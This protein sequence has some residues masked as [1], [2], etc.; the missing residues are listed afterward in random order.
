MV[1]VVSSVGHSV[2]DK[3]EGLAGEVAGSRVGGRQEGPAAQLRGDDGHDGAL[4]HGK[5]VF[6]EPVSDNS[7][8]E[9]NV[10][11]E[12]GWCEEGP[13]RWCVCDHD[14]SQAEMNATLSPA[15]PSLGPHMC[16][17]KDHEQE[18]LGGPGCVR[19]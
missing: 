17:S 2:S 13:S 3:R 10:V 16:Q 4:C 5:V 14:Q 12:G 11:S 15:G 6:C 1:T 18:E 9:G 7:K 8:C 19:M